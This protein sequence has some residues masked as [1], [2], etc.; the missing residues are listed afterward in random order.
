MKEGKLNQYSSVVTSNL[1]DALQSNVK[2]KL[3]LQ[4]VL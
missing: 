3:T 2:E 4:P 1:L